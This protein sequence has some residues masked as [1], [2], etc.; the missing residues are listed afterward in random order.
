VSESALRNDRR[1][2]RLALRRATHVVALATVV[3]GLATARV[4]LAGEAEVAQSTAALEQGEPR[5]AI[6]HAR[7]AAGWYAPGAPHVGVAYTRLKALARAAEQRRRWDV[8]LLAWQAIR[9]AA[10]ETRWVVIPHGAD[11]ALANQELARIMAMPS[12]D[13]GS[14]TEPDARL[15]AEFLAQLS[16][17][18]RPSLPWVVVL[19]S[20]FALGAAGL[21]LWARQ[22]GQGAVTAPVGKWWQ[23]AWLRSRL[24]AALA[25]LG[26]LLWLL[27]LWQA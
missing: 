1:S 16:R 14:A 6:V 9:S 4:L 21:V 3:L 20:G 23:G 12:A 17:D 15:A 5:E 8:A 27:A 18:T 24:G 22:M 26:V 19:L 2:A 11:L 10:L 13:T 7:R 25:G